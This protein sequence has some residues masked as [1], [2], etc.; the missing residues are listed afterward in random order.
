MQKKG[1]RENESPFLL[2]ENARKS[3]VTLS[4]VDKGMSRSSM[5]MAISR[6]NIGGGEDTAIQEPGPVDMRPG[7]RPVGMPVLLLQQQWGMERQ[8]PALGQ[9][10]YW[11]GRRV[12]IMVK[13]ILRKHTHHGQFFDIYIYKLMKSWVFTVVLTLFF[14]QGNPEGAETCLE[15]DNQL[16]AEKCLGARLCSFSVSLQEES[17]FCS[18][19]WSGT[20]KNLRSPLWPG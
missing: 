20:A 15:S 2:E 1:S 17:C 4:L 9:G 10:G 8:V 3:E 6:P 16:A 13:G 18:V 11:V 7:V 5:K 14:R 12:S 19:A